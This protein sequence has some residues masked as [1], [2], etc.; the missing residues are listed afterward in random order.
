MA[1]VIRTVFR[2]E[3]SPP[4]EIA[5]H[6]SDGDPLGC[7]AVLRLLPRALSE[8]LIRPAMQKSRGKDIDQAE[9]AISRW[10]REHTA[11][12]LADTKGLMAIFEDPDSVD[13]Y[14][15]FFPGLKAGEAVSL[16]GKWSEEFKARFFQDHP[17]VVLMLVDAY[18]RLAKVG[19]EE[20]LE[21]DEKKEPIWPAGSP[22]A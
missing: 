18:K 16:N 17:E 15:S 8:R 5:L 4:R 11:K 6:D 19:T 21:D 13:A 3:D 9:E 12:A 1:A 20:R 2:L 10:M 14:S 7:V 22:S